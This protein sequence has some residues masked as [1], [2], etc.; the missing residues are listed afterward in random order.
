[1]LAVEAAGAGV[2][3]RDE[4][5]PSAP[6]ALDRVLGD[7]IIGESPPMHEVRELIDKVARLRGDH[8]AHRGRVGHRQ[9]TG[10]P[11]ASTTAA[12]ARD[13]PLVEVNCSRSRR[14]CSRTS[15]SAT[16]GARSPTRARSRRGW[17]SCATAARCSSTRWGTCRSAPRPCCCASSTSASSSAWAAPRTSAVDMRI[18]AATNK[19][20]EDEVDARPLPRG[21][22]LPAQGGDASTL[23]PL[24]ERGDDVLLLARHFL[25]EFSAQVQEGVPRPHAR[26]RRGCCARYP[27]PGNVRELRNLIERVVLLEDGRA[28]RRR[29]PAARGARRARRARPPSRDRAVPLTLAQIEERH[30]REVLRMT[31]GQQVAR[32]AHP[33]HLAP[34]AHREAEAHGLDSKRRASAEPLARSEPV[35]RSRH[36]RKP[37]KSRKS[38]I[39]H[40]IRCEQ[41]TDVKKH[42]SLI[43]S[44][45]RPA[46]ISALAT[47]PRPKSRFRNRLRD[48]HSSCKIFVHPG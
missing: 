13:C 22:L 35:S 12:S 27:W 20:L 47:E 45:R 1:M 39:F 41:P 14:P 2:R 37:N 38:L 33:R 10:R 48:M 31:D 24:R 5:E 6:R 30:I 4:L 9:G 26:G 7:E 36:V 19:R 29:A 11:R 21:P 23:P 16:S 15:C 3:A 8:G 32:G 40:V 44:S 17:S 43:R 42:D 46:T 18:V 25:R 34:D 28:A